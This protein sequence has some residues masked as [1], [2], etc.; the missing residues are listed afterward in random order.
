MAG[1]VV[2]VTLTMVVDDEKAEEF[3]E[4]GSSVY[5]ESP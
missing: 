5:L 2:R 1:P 4:L 3:I